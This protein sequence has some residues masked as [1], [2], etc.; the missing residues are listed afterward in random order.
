MIRFVYLFNYAE[1]VSKQDGETWYLTTHMPLVKELPE[2]A[3]T[4]VTDA[5]A[6]PARQGE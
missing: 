1:G 3:W 5:I 4:R 2:G 6:G